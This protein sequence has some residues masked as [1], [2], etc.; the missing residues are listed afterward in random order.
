MGLFVAIIWIILVF[1]LASTAKKRGRSYSAFFLISLFL[2]PLIGFIFLIL[3]GENKEAIQKQNI[4][5]GISK[6]CPFC[7]NEIK[8]EAIVCQYCGK[9]LPKNESENEDEKNKQIY[10]EEEI[11]VDKEGRKWR[12]TSTKTGVI[13]PSYGLYGINGTEIV[14]GEG[15]EIWELVDDDDKESKEKKK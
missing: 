2:S 15:G 9:D 3:I 8:K 11:M 10:N 13:V 6:I 4:L 5:N 14:T 1:I 7:A 12:K